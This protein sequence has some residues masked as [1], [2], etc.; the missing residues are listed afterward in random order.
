MKGMKPMKPEEKDLAAKNDAQ[1]QP[2][3]PYATPKLTIHGD[4]EKIT[5]Y[6]GGQS[7]DSPLSTGGMTDVEPP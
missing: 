3:K 6:M 4:V 7:G 2:K 1:E 5:E